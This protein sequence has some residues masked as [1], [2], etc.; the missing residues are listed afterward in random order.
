MFF[1]TKTLQDILA[2]FNKTVQDLETFSANSRN[3]AD[4]KRK[5]AEVLA[6]EADILETDANKA[7]KVRS[8]ILS[9]LEV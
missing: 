3:S 4:T 2:G 1:G 9:M 6:L 5:D 8:N 7:D